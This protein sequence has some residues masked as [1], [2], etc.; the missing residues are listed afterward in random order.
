MN[1]ER[2]APGVGL[3]WPQSIRALCL[4]YGND[5]S[6]IA[7]LL[8]CTAHTVRSWCTGRMRR[9]EQSTIRAFR[10][11]CGWTHK[12]LPE[13]LFEATYTAIAFAEGTRGMPIGY[14]TEADKRWEECL[15]LYA[16]LLHHHVEPS[17]RYPG[18]EA[19]MRAHARKFA[20]ALDNSNKRRVVY[21]KP[22]KA[23]GTKHD[24]RRCEMDF[25]PVKGG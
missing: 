21:V 17:N 1:A 19:R 20:E 22:R 10:E 2:L 3:P 8:G 13:E 9:V 15:K 12:E 5:Y 18:H 11:R 23:R 4:A 14:P 25:A 7:A 16:R 6:R 24:S